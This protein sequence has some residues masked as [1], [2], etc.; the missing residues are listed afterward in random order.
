MKTDTTATPQDVERLI[1]K[2]SGKGWLNASTLK[3]LTGW[4]DRKIRAVANASNGRVISGQKGYRLTSEATR[5]EI[6]HACNW[7]RHQ[8]TEMQRRAQQ[9]VMAANNDLFFCPNH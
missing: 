2:L 3:P 8:A 9:I 4:N 1:A 6:D 5:A 7:L